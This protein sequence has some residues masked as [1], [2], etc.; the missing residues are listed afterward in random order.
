MPFGPLNAGYRSG[1]GRAR[2]APLPKHLQG[3]HV[4]LFGPADGVKMC[5]YAMNAGQRRLPREPAEV[6]ELLANSPLVPMW[7]ADDE[8]SRTPLRAGILASLRNILQCMDGTLPSPQPLVDAPLRSVPIKR[9][10]GLGMPCHWMRVDGHLVPLHLLDLC[11]HVFYAW[12]LGER[13]L[14]FY[15]PKLENELEARYLA[16]L[17][18]ATEELLPA[19]HV[20]GS[21]RVLVILENPRAVFR[22]NEMMDELY[23]YFAGAS[24]GW[25]D[26]VA[27]AARLFRNDPTY[28][29]PAKADAQIVVRHIRESHRLLAQVVSA[30]GGV[31]IGGMYGVLPV[32][33]G[34]VDTPTMQACLHGLVRD[35]VL[36]LRRGLEGFWLAHPDFVRIG[37]A[38]VVAHQQGLPALRK[39]VRALVLDQG[40]ADA[41]CRLA[42]PAV[43]VDED[44]G[45]DPQD[46]L[47]PRALLAAELG[48]AGATIRN[49]HPDEVR[50][51]SVQAMQYITDWLIGNGCVAL[52]TTLQHPAD[53]H[54]K[55]PVRVMDDLAT[56]ERSRWEV[57]L[58]LQ[59]GRLDPITAVCIAREELLGLRDGVKV[60]CSF[61]VSGCFAPLTALRSG[62]HGPVAPRV[63]ARRL[64]S[65]AALDI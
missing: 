48:G 56:T 64:S 40:V 19:A 51:N 53:V 7:G 52:P 20:R 30:R 50:Y 29:M 2:V 65:V 31:A 55:L 46:P 35:V 10:P 37:M 13:A 11:L 5:G 47:Y 28:R 43:A 26:Y 58:E 1:E 45:L 15:I 25:H 44:R 6:A 4:T 14:S 22:L 21:I 62:Q 9:V 16:H 33:T 27:A 59:H 24:L 54:A 60:G 12:P 36:Q 63:V 41:L 23:P 61:F 42:D 17:L 32:A 18:R 38:L 39:L 49:N 8:D 57:S 3:P 34:A